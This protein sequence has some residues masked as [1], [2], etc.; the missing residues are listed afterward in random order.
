MRTVGLIGGTGWVSTAEYYKLINEGVNKREGSHTFPDLLI[1][2]LNY[3]RLMRLTK[4][5]KTADVEHML[6]AAAKQLETAGAQGL[7]LCANTLHRYAPAVSTAVD[8]PLLHIADAVGKDILKREASKVGLIGT[9]QTMEM[10]FYRKSLAEMYITTL[11]PSEEDRGFIEDIIE[12]ELIKNYFSED[13]RLRFIE[14]IETLADKG[15]QAV[16]LGC[17]EIPLLV[18]QDQTEVPLIDSLKTHADL[19]VSFILGDTER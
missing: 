3:G 5:N 17:T 13:S 4:E 16:I 1:R 19:A 6:T 2:S 12:N 18:K 14:I 9:R 10:D 7:M 8:I 11:I 15:A